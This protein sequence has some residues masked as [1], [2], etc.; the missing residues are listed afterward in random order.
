[1]VMTGISYS[2]VEGDPYMGTE[3]VRR[4]SSAA[5]RLLDLVEVGAAVAR[6]V[7][8]QWSLGSERLDHLGG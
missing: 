4:A 5:E 1:M 8:R 6:P 2:S 3:A 7:E